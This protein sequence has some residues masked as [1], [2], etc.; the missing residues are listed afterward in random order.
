MAIWFLNVS[1]ITM[2]L[3]ILHNTKHTKSTSFPYVSFN[4]L[5]NNN[6][7]NSNI[8]FSS[9]YFGF[10][11]VICQNASQTSKCNCLNPVLGK[12]RLSSHEY[13]NLWPICSCF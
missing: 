11:R 8:I 5:Y 7:N 10:I 4:I 12:M 9:I 1:I 13:L 2:V 3:Q 6:N